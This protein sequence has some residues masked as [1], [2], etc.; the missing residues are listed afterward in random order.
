MANDTVVNNVKVKTSQSTNY[1]HMHM[2]CGL[3]RAVSALLCV[4]TTLEVRRTRELSRIN[5]IVSV[6]CDVS[7]S[8]VCIIQFSYLI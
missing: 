6:K 4:V 5:R 7:S 3:Y 2:M 1:N 8:L